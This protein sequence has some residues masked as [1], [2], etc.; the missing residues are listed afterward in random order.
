[1]KF[2]GYRVHI[3]LYIAV[4]GLLAVAGIAFIFIVLYKMHDK[5]DDDDHDH[6]GRED[7]DEQS[8]PI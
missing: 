3:S 7:K 8:V 6:N 1:M 4:G 5:F 2:K